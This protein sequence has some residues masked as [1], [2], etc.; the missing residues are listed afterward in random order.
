MFCPP[1]RGYSHRIQ[2]PLHCLAFLLPWLIVFEVGMLWRRT[3]EP[4]HAMPSL[5]A[6]RLIS[7]LFELV[8]AG[9]IYL[10]GLLLVAILL[11]WH[12]ASRQPW[13]IDWPTV[14]GMLGES[15]VWAIPLYVFN[16]LLLRADAGGLFG[17]WLDDVILSIGAGM[18]EELVFRL[19]A[20]TLLSLLLI[21]IFGLN[22][23][24]TL[25]FIFLASAGLFAA[26]HHRP[27]GN[28]PF[29][30]AQFLFRTAAGLYLTGIF[31]Y[32]G[33]GIAAGSHAIYDVVAV[34]V[35]TLRYADASP[36]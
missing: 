29:D 18:Y 21:D 25:V 15:L 2:Q 30:T 24:A 26:H 5:V 16:S 13:T 9:G 17:R 4:N 12:L 31:I 11:G 23:N 1:G 10:P 14:L 33:F 27:F 28:E 34:T 20:I 6:W 7:R 36:G 3:V 32:R 22:K 35:A 19:M 8:G